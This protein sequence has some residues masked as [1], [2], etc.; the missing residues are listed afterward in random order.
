MN[1]SAKKDIGTGTIG[2]ASGLSVA[3]W[4]TE[5][6]KLPTESAKHGRFA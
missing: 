5:C 1:V 3:E 2:P 4:I 6:N